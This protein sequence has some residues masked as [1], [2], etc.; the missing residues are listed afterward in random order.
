MKIQ[1]QPYPQ[2]N[3]IA[4]QWL[5]FL[6]LAFSAA[7]SQAQSSNFTAA[8]P[9]VATNVGKPNVV[10]ALDI[11]GSMKQV[12]YA[13][14]GA[15]NWK[16]GLHDDFDPTYS[17]YGYFESNR[18]YSYAPSTDKQFFYEDG[19]G[20]WDGNYLNWLTMRRMDVVRKVLVGGKVRDRA[21]EPIGGSTWFVLEGQNEP[22]DYTFKKSYSNSAAFSP[23]G[24]DKEVLIS[25][26]AFSATTG[27][28]VSIV[29][30]SD[31]VE[32][33]QLSIDRDINNGSGDWHTVSFKNTYVSIPSVVATAL[34][35]NGGHQSLARVKDITL[36]NFKV[37]VDEWDYL[38][39]NHTTE[40]VVFVVAATGNHKIS[41]TDKDTGIASSYLVAA[42]TT[43]VNATTPR[44]ATFNTIGMGATFLRQPVLFTGTSSFNDAQPVTTRVKNI[45][46]TSFE[47]AMQEER[48]QSGN[49]HSGELVSWIAIERTLGYSAYAGVAIEIDNTSNSHTEIWQDV[50]LTANLFN[51]TPMVAINVQTTNGGDPVVARYG[52][53]GV[54]KDGFDV[55]IEEEDSTGVGDL[56]HPAAEAIGYL[57]VEA[58]TGYKIRLGVQTEPTGILQQNSASIRFGMAVYNYDHSLA[59]TSIYNNN[60]VHGGTFKPCYPD[61]SKDVASRTNFDICMDTHVKSPLSNIIDVIEDHP[62][63]WGTTP[64]AETL[65]DIKGY[66]S[67]QNFNRGTGN[68]TQ[69]YNNGTEGTS[70][71]RN[72]Y[73]ISD[74]WDPYYYPEFSARLPCAKSFVLHFNDG[75]PYKDFDGNASD[76]PVVENDRIGTYYENYMLDDLALELRKYDCRSDAGMTGH[77]DIISYYVYAAL[78]EGEAFNS[79]SLRMREAA[80]NGGFVDQDGDHLPTPGHPSNFNNYMINGAGNCTPNEW[81]EDGDCNP[82]TF[83][84]AS[85]AEELVN[86]LNAALES[87]TARSGSGGASSVIAASRS[88]EG[89][90]FNA[91]FR[92]SVTSQGDEVT[93]IG[94]VHALMIDDAGN[95][96]HDDGD[97]ILEASDNT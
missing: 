92:P 66:F 14:T 65:Y 91:I 6:T 3:T 49:A 89:A 20:L 34:S 67:Q 13:D 59:P 33:G 10:I 42:G 27:G 81:D 9:F 87:I 4:I 79:D 18:K 28:G 95:L 56:T 37:R 54:S 19:G 16:S 61:I 23:I 74:T 47:I 12:A 60:T 11:S 57:A 7:L 29:E 5:F 70:G 83:Y 64:I 24:N 48:S 8:P 86:Q 73:E 75:A 51:D 32:V 94:D 45:S 58:S 22:L 63:I 97:R 39:G 55:M 31:K 72:S 93:W 78:G 36:T 85:D 84:F 62:L 41:I 71:Q 43:T 96:R 21:G 77:Q 69:W 17:Y 35:Y 25:E 15:G 53:G 50:N 46:T 88:G 1:R 82:D 2:I 80:A 30:L 26:G 38:D 40:D 90:V 68:H 52:N 76:H 44:N